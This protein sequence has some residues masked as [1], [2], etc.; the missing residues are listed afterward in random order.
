LEWEVPLLKLAGWL[1]ILLTTASLFSLWLKPLRF[2]HQEVLAGGF[3][4][5]ILS[6]ISVR[7]FNVSGATFLSLVI[8]VL[9]VVLGTGISFISL[10]RHS[11]A[12]C[13][14]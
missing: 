2:Y 10:V 5:E 1:M 14:G 6:R 8:L 13:A 9:S 11:E 4:G 12:P 7:Y 3:V